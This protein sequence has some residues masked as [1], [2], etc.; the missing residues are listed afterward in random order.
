MIFYE[1][2]QVKDINLSLDY[3]TYMMES[4][5]IQHELVKSYTN[6]ALTLTESKT[7]NIL[8]ESSET[9]LA[10]RINN[11][12]L[13]KVIHILKVLGKFL[14]KLWKDL[15]TFIKQLMF[16]DNTQL[17]Q[18]NQN[19]YDGI[20]TDVLSNMKYVWREPTQKLLDII[21]NGSNPVQNIED[22]DEIFNMA[23]EYTAKARELDVAFVTSDNIALSD[24]SM[25]LLNGV[26]CNNIS[27]FKKAYMD[28][29]LKPAVRQV[30]MDFA[31]KSM[32]KDGMVSRSIIS[33]IETSAKEQQKS[34]EKF[35]NVI[36]NTKTSKS[37][38]MAL[39]NKYRTIV[40][41]LNNVAVAVSNS[42]AESVNVYVSQC[43]E[44]FVKIL[45]HAN[46]YKDSMI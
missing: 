24:I 8:K 7:K 13:D 42:I 12:A 45:H 34:I 11:D 20:S 22:L 31:R 36:E 27:M 29:L 33:K 26:P 46:W 32:I 28:S 30:G 37:A 43:R 18:W 19:I 14:L 5:D 6:N 23:F 38:D 17:L 21:S 9:A 15:V 41:T 2:K 39:V 4:Y 1:G 25:K 3:Y 16:R 35:I 44:T 10:E 40:N